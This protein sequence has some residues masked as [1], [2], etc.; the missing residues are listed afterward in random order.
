M[1]NNEI[2]ISKVTL[3]LLNK[4]SWQDISLSEI[5]KKSKINNFKNIINNKND[6][7]KLLNKYFDNIILSQSSSIEESS[8]KDMIFEILMMRFD[9]LETYRVAVTS[10]FKSFKKTPKDLLFFMPELLDSIIFMMNFTKIDLKGIRG[11][12]KIK[13]ILLIYI[14][15]FLVW[16]RDDSESLDKTMTFLDKYLDKSEK[17]INYIK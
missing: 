8:N 10:I 5:N 17:V 13:G 15:T 2:K 7:L 9:I 12:L 3:L 11:S 1:N 4:K 14:S 6:L 16:I